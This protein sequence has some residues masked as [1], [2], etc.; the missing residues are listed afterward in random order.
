GCRFG[1]GGVYAG[2]P[3]SNAAHATAWIY[4]DT[5]HGFYAAAAH[6][7]ECEQRLPLQC[8]FACAE[9]CGSQPGYRKAAAV[10]GVLFGGLGDVSAGG[11]TAANRLVH[12]PDW[13]VCGW[14]IL[15]VQSL[16]LRP[17]DDRP[18]SFA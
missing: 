5:R 13:L 8:I 3:C 4:S 6:A 12:T 7:R 14:R 11:R 1:G 2:K 17:A 18:I 15:Y 9:C 10:F 16:H